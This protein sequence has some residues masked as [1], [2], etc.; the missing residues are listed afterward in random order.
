MC[1]LITYLLCNNFLSKNSILTFCA[2]LSGE[3]IN[4]KDVK[5]KWALLI[6]SE[7]HGL[8]G[9]IIYDKK[10]TIQKKGEIE[11]LNVSVATGI[12]LNELTK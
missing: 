2:D 7:A 3:K 4:N 5:N 9:K 6:G 10:I 12:L 1:L 11:S 8:S